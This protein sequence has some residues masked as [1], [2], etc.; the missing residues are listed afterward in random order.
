ML[1]LLIACALL[2]VIA[3]C[4]PRLRRLFARKRA[5]V[6]VDCRKPLDGPP[7]IGDVP[8]CKVCNG[9]DDV[10]TLPCRHC[11]RP[12]HCSRAFNARGAYADGIGCRA[13]EPSAWAIDQ[14][15]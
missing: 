5:V 10:M 2:L 1:Y 6:C 9:L 14:A 8:I 4:A 3:A 13:C 11:D 15:V 12:V 7:A